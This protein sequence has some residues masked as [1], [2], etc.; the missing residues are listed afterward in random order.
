MNHTHHLT[1]MIAGALLS[2]GVALTGLGL[3]TAHA[4]PAIY[5]P[6]PAGQPQPDPP[7][8]PISASHDQPESPIVRIGAQPQPDP[9]GRP[10]TA[11]PQI[12][13]LARP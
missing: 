6:I 13:G 3:A 12:A 4:S 5:G 2:G 10:I 7:G 8:R 1:R 9:P 11:I